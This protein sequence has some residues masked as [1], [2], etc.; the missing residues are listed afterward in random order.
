M[1]N[2][3]FSDMTKRI[4]EIASILEKGEVSLEESL[5]LFSEAS[6]LIA[7]C[8]GT[9]KNA[10]FKITDIAAIDSEGENE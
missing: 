5:E 8:N 2:N 4:E 9:L 7:K 3:T 10:R 1:M 6:A